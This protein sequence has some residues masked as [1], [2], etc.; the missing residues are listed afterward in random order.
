MGLPGALGFEPVSSRGNDSS[1]GSCMREQLDALENPTHD[2]FT[3]LQCVLLLVSSRGGIITKWNSFCY[4]V[5]SH[6]RFALT[7]LFDC[8]SVCSLCSLK[9]LIRCV[10]DIG[11]MLG[12]HIISVVFSLLFSADLWTSSWAK[13]EYYQALRCYEFRKLKPIQRSQTEDVCTH[14]RLWT[15]FC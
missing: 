9:P 12:Y 10:E 6:R 3:D 14:T 11:K 2:V 5:S 7:V 4:S 13:S 1:C 15:A 8:F